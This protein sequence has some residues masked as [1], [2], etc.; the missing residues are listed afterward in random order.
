MTNGRSWFSTY[1]RDSNI[2]TANIPDTAICLLPVVLICTLSVYLYH[3]ST[4]T[5]LQ[6]FAAVLQASLELINKGKKELIIH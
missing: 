3:C 6:N 1:G 4:V 5:T 2:K